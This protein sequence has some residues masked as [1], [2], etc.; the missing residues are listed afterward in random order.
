MQVTKTNTEVCPAYGV[1]EIGRIFNGTGNF[2]ERQ[3][4]ELLVR[5]GGMLPL[6]KFSY[7]KT[8][9]RYFQH[10]QADSCVEKVP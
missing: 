5:C 1:P 10:S 6:R 7:L 9:K 3:W 2:C 4:S 8:L